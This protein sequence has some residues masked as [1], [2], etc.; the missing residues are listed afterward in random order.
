M[1]VAD[2]NYAGLCG[3]AAEFNRRGSP[4]GPEEAADPYVLARTVRREW[5]SAGWRPPHKQGNSLLS[6]RFAAAD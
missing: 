5:V 6:A 3:H 2:R 4:A 1:N